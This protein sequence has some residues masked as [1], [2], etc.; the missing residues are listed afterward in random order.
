MILS[1]ILLCSCNS[2]NC[3]SI[4][5]DALFSKNIL[6]LP[7]PY[8][9]AGAGPHLYQIDLSIE[10]M[11]NKIEKDESLSLKAVNN[12]IFIMKD[13]DG[14]TKDYYCILYRGGNQYYFSD[15]CGT[16]TLYDDLPEVEFKDRYQSILLPIHLIDDEKISKDDLGF[17]VLV[18][19]ET[20][21]NMDEY[22][23][24]YNDSGW[25]DVEKGEDY[26]II[27][28]YKD[29]EKVLSLHDS[30]IPPTRHLEFKTPLK[31]QFKYDDK[32]D[33]YLFNFS[34]IENY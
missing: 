15:M 32:L 28:G 30:Q 22:Y 25:Y 18:E 14:K 21:Y 12:N 17:N 34:T 6:S 7:I 19:Y 9:Y 20:K 10:E 5:K 16:L 26:I 11:Y 8:K 29:E 31:I 2:D 27:N 13:N 33:K 24:F 4:Q 1:I 3:K 23:D